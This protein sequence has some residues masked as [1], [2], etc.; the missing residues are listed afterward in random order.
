MY[1]FISHSSEDIDL[2]RDFAGLLGKQGIRAWVSEDEV[3]PGDN[4][5]LKVGEA[6][7]KSNAMIVLL[8]PASA[9]SPWV[10]S[11]IT[12]A[13]V[14]RRYRN[15]LW[16]VVARRTKVPWILRQSENVHV[17]EDLRE[18]RRRLAGEIREV[19][20]APRK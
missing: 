13:L 17:Y 2:A 19:A 6:L 7:E 3:F 9:D 16:A 18:A 5:P 10:R 20:K 15:R 14:N 12:Y 11:E 1:V 8:S 4:Y